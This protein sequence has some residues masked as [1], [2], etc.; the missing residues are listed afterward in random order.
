MSSAPV[1]LSEQVEIKWGE[2]RTSAQLHRTPRRV[3]RIDVQPSGRVVVYAPAGEDLIR[4]QDRVQRKGPWIF[5]QL[6]RIS[7]SPSTPERHFISGET[8]LLLGKQYR[9]SIEQSDNPRVAIEGTRLNVWVKSLDDQSE[10]RRLLEEFYSDIAREVFN[11]RLKEV[12]P[13]FLRK[14]LEVPSLLIRRL[15]KRWGSYT[16]KGRIVLNVDLV[17]ASTSLIDYVICHELSHAFYPDH[18]KEWRSLFFTVMPD[19]EN[20]KA[21]LE[22]TLR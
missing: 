20:R 21:T 14:G 19:W 22:A 8:H 9:L 11:E 5:R 12:A 18:G 13:P 3:L 1:A 17:R 4:I 10:C 15:S 16:P 7:N 2:R 6:D